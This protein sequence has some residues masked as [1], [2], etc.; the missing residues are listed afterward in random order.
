MRKDGLRT[1]TSADVWFIPPLLAS[2]LVA[3]LMGYVNYHLGMSRTGIVL[4]GRLL[5]CA[6]LF[7]AVYTF[8]L[9]D[10]SF[11]RW[12]SAAFLSPLV[13]FPAMVVP[14]GFAAMWDD[15]GRFQGL[16]L[17]QNPHAMA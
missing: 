6:A 11:R 9:R 7:L 15:T 10:T 5:T 1:L 12:V 17:N 3:T 13:L 4:L 2:I 8:L 14:N 16:T